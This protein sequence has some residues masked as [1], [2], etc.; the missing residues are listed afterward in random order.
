MNWGTILSPK[1]MT[2]L[3]GILGEYTPPKK[4]AGGYVVP[5]HALDLTT[6]LQNDFVFKQGGKA[7][8]QRNLGLWQCSVCLRQRKLGICMIPAESYPHPLYDFSPL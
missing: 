8:R 6:S 4:W 2:M 5:A 3:R 7:F 1:M